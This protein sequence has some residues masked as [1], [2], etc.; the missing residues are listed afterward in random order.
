[1]DLVQRCLDRMKQ[2]RE[3]LVS[4]F[5]QMDVDPEA[6]QSTADGGT[7]GRGSADYAESVQEVMEQE[8]ERMRTEDTTLPPL[9]PHRK[10]GAFLRER[11]RPESTKR[12]P[13]EDPI[14]NADE[15]YEVEG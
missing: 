4:R 1:M 13:Q 8:W 11:V 3:R 6:S 5:R 7:P 9:T 10:R 12:R 15:E 2:S 14:F